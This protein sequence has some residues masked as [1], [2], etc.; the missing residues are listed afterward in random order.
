MSLGSLPTY[1]QSTLFIRPQINSEYSLS[2]HLLLGTKFPQSVII[3][4]IIII[5]Q[6]MGIEKKSARPPGWLLLKVTSPQKF[7]LALKCS[8]Q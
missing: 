8:K 2:V 7:S 3:I 5:K 4:I 6:G 1:I